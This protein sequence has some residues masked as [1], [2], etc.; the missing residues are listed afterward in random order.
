M[1]YRISFFFFFLIL[2]TFLS[3]IEREP[4]LVE[5]LLIVNYWNK[6]L[7]EKFPV[8]YD[9]LLQ[10][11][12]FSMP[13]ARMGMEGEIGVGYGSIPPYL[14]YNLRVQLTSFLEISGTYR[15]FKGVEDPV[16][17]K[18]GFG[19]LSDKGANAKISIFTPED[20]HY[21]LPGFAIGFQDFMG[22]SAF[23]AYY[24][25]LTQVF[26][27]QNVEISIG[28]GMHRIQGWFGGLLWIP[29]R[30]SEW[31]YLKSLAFAAEYDAIPYKNPHLEPHPKGRLKNTPWHLGVKYRLWDCIDLSYAY[32]RGN[33][34]AFTASTFYN[35][36]ECQGLLPKINDSCP[37]RAPLNLER[38]GCYRS[39]QQLVQD[40]SYAM[41]AQGF[42][43]AEA[44][45][46][47]EDHTKR[48][49][50]VI[51]NFVYRQEKT[52]RHRLN[53]LLASLIPD[54]IEE[55][56]VTIDVISSPIQE[57]RYKTEHLRRFLNEEIGRFE[58]EILTP[59]RNATFPNPYTAKQIFKEE[60]EWW[61]L[62]ILPKTNT[63]F[64]SSTGKFKY[65]LGVS[66]NVNGFV[67]ENTFYTIS[68]GYFFFSDIKHLR[69]F[70][71]LNPSQIINVRSDS[72]NYF[73]PGSL[74]LDE[75]YLEKI[76][77][78]GKGW[79]TRISLGYFETMY[80][81]LSAEWLYYPVASSWAVGMDLAIVKKRNPTGLGFSP[82][83]RKLHGYCPSY[84][85]FTGSHCFLNL[86][87]DSKRTGL[88]FKTSV[89][90]FL[91]ND[92]GARFECA[93]YFCSGLKIGF[94]YTYTNGKDKINGHTY[95]D[96]GVFF[97]VP[98]DIFYTH[99]SR[100]RWGYGMSAWLRDVGATA[101]TGTHLY[102]LINEE[103]Q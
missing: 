7:N 46:D 43:L 51:S 83:I 45:I 99:T 92:Y 32:L 20:S 62:E 70:D 28:Y 67:W 77:N 94:W 30:Q 96:K 72:M 55:V 49:R 29:F 100:S 95:Q 2:T 54:S 89:G 59:L 86:Y 52:V 71:R 64:G 15:T 17:T 65:A 93:R 48:L 24:A 78:L 11:G 1:L 85:K 53:H 73:R 81:G 18:F 34:W 14:H 13:S 40:L 103:R 19:D 60:R 22:T 41:H 102:D 101:F 63:V 35:F 27:K 39:E 87:Y 57:Y 84:R 74:T 50:L 82:T 69:D 90:K 66:T 21:K 97:S 23:K 61:N 76:W 33:A 10:G 58:L 38:I 37:Y 98:L 12:Y 42:D 91:A 26:L 47:C 25:V 8:T 9:H 56:I 44:W 80:G 88:E 75:A 16:L 79:F 6:R 4:N 3:S 5:D 31:S 68:L 36:G